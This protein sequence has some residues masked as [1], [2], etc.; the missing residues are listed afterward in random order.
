MNDDISPIAKSF[1]FV[2]ELYSCNNHIVCLENRQTAEASK[3]NSRF[4]RLKISIFILSSH[5]HHQAVSLVVSFLCFSLCGRDRKEGLD[6][7]GVFLYQ[8]HQFRNGIHFCA[9]IKDPILCFPSP[10]LYN[11]GPFRIFE[12]I[13]VLLYLALII[14]PYSLSLFSCAVVAFHMNVFYLSIVRFV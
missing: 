9:N 13:C 3:R 7:F 1:H 10:S 8:F 4:G 12:F 11:F 5:H 14:L 2:N 6:F